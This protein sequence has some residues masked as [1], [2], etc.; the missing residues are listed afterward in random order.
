MAGSP[1]VDYRKQSGHDLPSVKDE[2]W[3]FW[4]APLL[5]YIKLNPMSISEVENWLASNRITDD[6]GK[7]LLAYL[8]FS[9]KIKS[10]NDKWHT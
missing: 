8:E 2:R 3:E 4:S 1:I 6:K 7:N 10:T 9:N 5:A